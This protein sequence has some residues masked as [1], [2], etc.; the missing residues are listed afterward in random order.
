MINLQ[1]KIVDQ[2][3]LVN[4]ERIPQ[5]LHA[6]IE[7]KLESLIS[8]L[9]LKVQENLSGK[10]LNTKS[11]ALLSSLV[12][13]VEKLGSLLVGFVA[14]EPTD[15]KVEAY[16]MAHEYGGKGF[17]EIVPV[18]KLILRFE[19]KSGEIIFA[20]YVFHPPAAE[21]SYLRSALHEM[22]PEIEAGLHQA[23]QD[24]IAP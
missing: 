4:L 9:R 5:R 17:Y 22:A 23:I 19:G 6:E 7:E 18:H 24:A 20:P 16:A 21:R 14:V 12:S 15:S 2:E 10:V 11:G 3:L 13:G 8:E 1:V